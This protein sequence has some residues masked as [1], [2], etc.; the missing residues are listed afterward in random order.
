MQSQDSSLLPSKQLYA[1]LPP[2]LK[3]TCLNQMNSLQP[4][5]IPASN[6]IVV[7][8]YFSR[9]IYAKHIKIK[10]IHNVVH[11]QFSV[12]IKFIEAWLFDD[13]HRL[14]LSSAVFLLTSACTARFYVPFMQLTSIPFQ[15]LKFHSEVHLK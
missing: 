15:L 2:T 12:H 11:M 6:S 14:R 5:V 1:S 8:L 7:L 10:N 13:E 4:S 9:V 3:Y